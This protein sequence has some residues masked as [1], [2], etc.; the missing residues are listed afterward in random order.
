[1]GAVEINQAV[2]SLYHGRRISNLVPVLVP[3]REHCGL[4][5]KGTHIP[6]LFYSHY[7]AMIRKKNHAVYSHFN[8]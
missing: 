6:S 2:Y 4:D 8:Y 1:M 7:V 5:L 3:S